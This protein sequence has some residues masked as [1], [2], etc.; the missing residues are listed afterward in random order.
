[1]LEAGK[2]FR[3][4]I[5]FENGEPTSNLDY[6]LYNSTGQAI[7]TASVAIASGRVS[8][9]IDIPAEHNS[10]TPGNLFE[11]RKLEWEYVT[12]SDVVSDSISYHIRPPINFPVSDD[13]VRNLLGVDSD[14]LSD[15]D[16]DLFSGYIYFRE[17]IGENAD[18]GIYENAG[19]MNAYRIARAI[20]AATALQIFPTL[21]IRLPR[22]YDSGT[23]AYERW[24]TINWQGLQAELG[25]IL[26]RGLQT[27][28]AEFEL[29]PTIEIFQLSDRGPDAIT[30]V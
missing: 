14:E 13:G 17:L 1:M 5:Q 21:Q 29:W 22:K 10:V 16:I 3:H 23:S 20:E 12:N 18:L 9:L 4:L 19:D 26:T 11:S 30:G 8:Y 2:K 28:N 25:A 6:T 27:V 15:K 24:N 7:V